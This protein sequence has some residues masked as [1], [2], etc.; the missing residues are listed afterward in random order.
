MK[1]FPERYDN[2]QQFNTIMKPAMLNYQYTY[3]VK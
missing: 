3:C 1:S 2:T